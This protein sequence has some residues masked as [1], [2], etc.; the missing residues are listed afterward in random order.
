MCTL[1]HNPCA[2]TC[3]KSA[4]AHTQTCLHVHT[5]THSYTHVNVQGACVHVYAHLHSCTHVHTHASV[6]MHAPHT[7]RP[8]FLLSSTVAKPGRTQISRLQTQH[9]FIHSSR[10]TLRETTAKRKQTTFLAGQEVTFHGSRGVQPEWLPSVQRY[11]GKSHLLSP[12]SPSNWVATS[13][14]SS[15]N[16][17]GFL[18]TQTW[19]KETQRPS[20]VGISCAGLN[21]AWAETVLPGSKLGEQEA[22]LP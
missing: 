2:H 9:S 12:I 8:C 15:R 19:K 14:T 6:L 17:N 21:S 16:S 5:C 7:H 11:L 18:E 4:H 22:P 20:E 3:I 13:L 10:S 1:V